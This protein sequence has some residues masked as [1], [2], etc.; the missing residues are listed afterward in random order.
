MQM[1]DGGGRNV[2]MENKSLLFLNRRIY[3]YILILFSISISSS[4]LFF[5]LFHLFEGREIFF[6]DN[7]LLNMYIWV[8]VGE[9]LAFLKFL[10]GYKGE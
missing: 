6:M 3:F 5:Y 4:S 7:F 10:R 2:D 9:I 1:C 8:K